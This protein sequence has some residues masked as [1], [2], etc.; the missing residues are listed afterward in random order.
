[1][2]PMSKVTASGVLCSVVPSS[3]SR[4]KESQNNIGKGILTNSKHFLLGQLGQR[5]SQPERK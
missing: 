5:G 4:A 2:L 1:M 3:L